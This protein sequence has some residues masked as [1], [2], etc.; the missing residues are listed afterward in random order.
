MVYARKRS[1]AFLDRQVVECGEQSGDTEVPGDHSAR[2]SVLTVRPASLDRV[3]PPAMAHVRMG[4]II[5]WS[6]GVNP[7]PS[8][9]R[10]G[11]AL[12]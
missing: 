2:P 3:Q 8:C 11:I 9:G 6:T 7:V 10:S 5:H 1:D 12:E 4:T